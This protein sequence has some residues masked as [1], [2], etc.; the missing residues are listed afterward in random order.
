[1]FVRRPGY[2][3]NAGAGEAQSS[4]PLLNVEFD[5]LGALPETDLVGDAK[6]LCGSGGR[7]F[8]YPT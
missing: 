6:I 8:A 7:F 4:C 3:W 2:Q 5:V 1:M